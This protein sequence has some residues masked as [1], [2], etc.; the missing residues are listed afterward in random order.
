MTPCPKCNSTMELDSNMVHRCESCERKLPPIWVPL[1][2]GELDTDSLDEIE[3]T[4][5]CFVRE[6]DA[7]I[8]DI[9]VA[10]YVPA[11]EFEAAQKRIAELETLFGNDTSWPLRDVLRRLADGADHLL[12]DHSCDAHGYEELGSA[13][14][15]ARSILESLLTEKPDD[16]K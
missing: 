12:K 11:S 7:I 4:C 6:T 10:K 1:F 15:A 16:A 13:R 2:N 9:T 3:T 14:D 5:G 8:E